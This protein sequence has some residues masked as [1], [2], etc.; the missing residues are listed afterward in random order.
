MTLRLL[1]SAAVVLV[2]AGLAPAKDEIDKDHAAKMARGLD[3]FKKHV[4][5]VLA[6]RPA[7]T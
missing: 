1:P 5:P 2:L 3:V 6:E 4:R 7:S